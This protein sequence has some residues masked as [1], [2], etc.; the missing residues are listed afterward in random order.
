MRVM[1]GFCVCKCRANFYFLASASVF[2]VLHLVHMACK[3]SRVSSPPLALLRLWSTSF[4]GVIRPRR[5][6][7]LH[8]YP[9]RSN[10]WARNLRQA[11]P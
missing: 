11:W 4:A 2:A 10:T 9:S 1:R 7:T 5:S 6:H 8:V 3:F